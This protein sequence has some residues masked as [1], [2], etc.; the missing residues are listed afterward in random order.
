MDFP[1]VEDGFQAN[2]YAVFFIVGGAAK[3]VPS[4]TPTLFFLE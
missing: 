4:R 3:K 2:L 1:E